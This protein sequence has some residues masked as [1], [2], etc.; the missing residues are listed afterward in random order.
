MKSNKYP[1]GS[2]FGESVPRGKRKPGWAMAAAAIEGAQQAA[3][4]V[5]VTVPRPIRHAKSAPVSQAE[6][7]FASPEKERAPRDAISEGSEMEMRFVQSSLKS[8]RSGGDLYEV[9]AS[10]QRLGV[11]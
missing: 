9:E 5:T 8:R 4:P 1:S 3:K 6:Y 2:E 11:A 10:Q 7:V